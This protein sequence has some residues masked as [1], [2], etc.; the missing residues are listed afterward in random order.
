MKH[1]LLRRGLACLIALIMTA[2]ALASCKGPEASSN[3]NN[4]TNQN[5]E[6]IALITQGM[7]DY[8]VIR[9]DT[10]TATVRQ[11]TADLVSALSKATGC[12]ITP[13]TDWVNHGESA[14]ADTPEI[15]VGL[16]NRQESIDAHAALGENE[17]T[18]ALVGKRL[19]IVGYNDESTAAAVAAF[20][21]LLP[22]LVT[23]GNTLTLDA[24]F[25]LMDTYVR[26]PWLNEFD[27]SSLSMYL[28]DKLDCTEETLLYFEPEADLVEY[29]GSTPVEGAVDM[30]IGFTCEKD[31]PHWTLINTPADAFSL[32]VDD[33]FA[34]TIKMWVYVNDIDRMGCDLDAVYNAPQVGSGTL[35][36]TLHDS[37]GYGHTWQHTF[38]GSG[39]HEIELSFTCHNVA[40]RNLEKIDYSNLNRLSAWCI[41]YEGLEVRFDDMRLCT[42][43]NDGYVQPE[44]PFGG[45]WL[46]TCDFEALDGPILT[47]WYGAFFDLDEKTQG[48]SSV[49]IVGHKENVD[50]RVCIGIRD[51]P[52]SYDEDTI[53]FDMYISSLSLLGTDWQI[54]LEHN[55]QAA[56][57]SVDYNILKDCAVDDNGKPTTLKGGQWNHIRLP[58]NKT[59]VVIGA[60][61]EDTF[62]NDL[63]L[64]QLVFYIA[65][66]GKTE[67]DNYLIRYDNF[68]VAKTEDLASGQ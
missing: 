7:S 26:Y 1:A 36:I 14:P 44:A 27:K 46:S 2:S 65:G 5:K 50:H 37:N 33:K 15:L 48:S 39:W 23:E 3:P 10:T 54:R 49:A 24:N 42:Y 18:V 68:Y 55:A 57:Y 60:G 43:E 13:G 28:G 12:A 34:Q 31:T 20:L 51:V 11:A 32:S 53:C 40:Y 52:V 16:T 30:G 35:Y 25:K 8:T 62:T 56:H 22:T 58:L 19:V 63:V 47:E 64:T 21:K 17:Y 6:V 38:Y 66:T 29:A 41:G 4:N 61:Y 9:P 67:A 59:R 45:R